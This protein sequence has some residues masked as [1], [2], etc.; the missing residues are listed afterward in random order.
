MKKVVK[1]LKLFASTI[2]LAASLVAITPVN[3]YAEE[4]EILWE[5]DKDDHKEED[6]NNVN[7]D[8]SIKEEEKT[9]EVK[10]PQITL[11]DTNWSPETDK[12]PDA[13]KYIPDTVETEAERKGIKPTPT[14]T[15]TPDT[16]TPTPTPVNPE[17]TPE[18]VVEITTPTPEVATKE[19]TTPIP[20]TGDA[21][22][23]ILISL[24]SAMVIA[25][26]IGVFKAIEINRNNKF[27]D[28]FYQE[29]DREDRTLRK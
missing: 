16:P 21:S 10:E 2:G 19:E 28:E 4:E 26:T 25:G 14:P 20:K 29:Q 18:T 9:E 6:I 7:P 3:V 23:Y 11:D 12:D 13:G 1:N 27:E 5:S 8:N 17:P 15:P 24:G 22:R